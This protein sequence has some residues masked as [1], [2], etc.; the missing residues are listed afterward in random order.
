MICYHK[1]SGALK[2]IFIKDIGK[3]V[4]LTREDAERALKGVT[5]KYVGGKHLRDNT[6]MVE[7]GGA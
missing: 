5:D 7:K 1:I 6:K 2:H 4:F 3:T